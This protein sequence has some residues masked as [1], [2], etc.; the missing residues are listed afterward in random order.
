MALSCS[1]STSREKKG[2]FLC[3]A[4]LTLVSGRAAACLTLAKKGM[5]DCL[6]AL[7]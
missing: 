2:V 5:P 6:E 3:A 1:E 4:L 7:V